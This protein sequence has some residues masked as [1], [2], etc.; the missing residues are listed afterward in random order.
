MSCRFSIVVPIYN[1][2]KY[3]GRCIDSILNQS[4]SDFE[5]VLVNDGST[6]GCLQ[7][8]RDY[9]NKDNRI[10]V[11]DK[12]NE[13][14]FAARITG[15]KQTVG[16]YIVHVDSDDFCAGTMLETL[17][18]KIREYGADL[19]IYNY[20]LVDES[21]NKIK[22]A[23]PV[24]ENNKVFLSED[25]KEIYAGMIASGIL[26]NIWLK[27]ARR[28][29]YELDRDYGR[30]INVKMGEDVIHSAPIIRNADKIL[31]ITDELYNYT[32][33]NS[34]MSK[35]LKKSYVFNF[36]LVREF[37][38]DSMLAD[39]FES[40]ETV[41]LDNVLKRSGKYLIKIAKLCDNRKDY[42]Q[43]HREAERYPV[44]ESA[45]NKKSRLKFKSRMF[46]MLSSPALYPIV[47]IVSRF[48]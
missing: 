3:L 14:L 20:A 37:L 18:G 1:V 40:L 41:Y 44:L 13:G 29:L 43:T 10:K 38:L 35:T 2:E 19:I 23:V 42:S 15:M 16:K 21:G 27:C 39:G 6:D 28:D 9:A 32:Y 47:R 31:Y 4:F 46:F 34:G 26:N 36:L 22:S 12:K 30:Y 25:K 11:I 24:F 17:D 45:L 7:I 33:N 5:L 48:V 8:C